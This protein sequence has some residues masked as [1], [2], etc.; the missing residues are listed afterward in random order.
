MTCSLL[1]LGFGGV[2]FIYLVSGA[3]AWERLVVSGIPGLLMAASVVIAIA[4]AAGRSRDSAGMEG[5]SAP[6]R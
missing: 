1:L 2:A 3:P 5:K 4:H 6:A